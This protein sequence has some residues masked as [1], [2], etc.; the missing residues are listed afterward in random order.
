MAQ[1]FLKVRLN[2]LNV[3]L[4]FIEVLFNA[5]FGDEDVGIFCFGTVE[6][7]LPVLETRIKLRHGMDELADDAFFVR[8]FARA[9][10]EE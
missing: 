5:S 3:V 2:L 9:I 8:S 1:N 7:R 10:A 4:T 6:C